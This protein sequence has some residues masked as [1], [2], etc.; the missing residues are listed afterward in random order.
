MAMAMT[1][2]TIYQID[3]PPTKRA[4]VQGRNKINK[5]TGAQQH[6]TSAQNGYCY[7]QYYGVFP[8][9]LSTTR[10]SMVT[11]RPPST[12]TSSATPFVRVLRLSSGVTP[13]QTLSIPAHRLRLIQC[14]VPRPGLIGSSNTSSHLNIGLTRIFASSRS[15]PPPVPM[16]DVL[17]CVVIS[18]SSKSISGVSL[19]RC[20]RIACVRES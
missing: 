17:I 15:V 20:T 3:D 4:N 12:R 5:N 9:T 13:S 19:P 7:Y 11:Y 14:P 10:R 2:M 8:P 1:I 6:M 18:S 16:V